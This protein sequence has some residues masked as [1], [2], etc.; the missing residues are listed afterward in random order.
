MAEGFPRQLVRTGNYKEGYRYKKNPWSN[1]D[2][3]HISFTPDT[4][5]PVNKYSQ[6]MTKKRRSL[7][8]RD[9]KRIHDLYQYKEKDSR[10]NKEIH[11]AAVHFDETGSNIYK[12]KRYDVELLRKI[13]ATFKKWSPQEGSGKSRKH[14]N[15]K[16]SRKR[17]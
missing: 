9:M 17:K 5:T 10:H 13:L 7:T 12:K 4:Y 1:Y 6:S 14:G 16:Y 11:D 3:L 15:K 2:K 8:Q